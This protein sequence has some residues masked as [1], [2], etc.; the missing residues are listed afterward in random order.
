MHRLKSHLVVSKLKAGASESQSRVR[1][2]KRDVTVCMHSFFVSAQS[3]SWLANQD[4]DDDL[5]RRNSMQS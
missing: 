1:C 5:I 3:P 4:D 2:D